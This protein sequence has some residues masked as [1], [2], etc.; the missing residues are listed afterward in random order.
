MQ[1][2]SWGLGTGLRILKRDVG[3]RQE[4]GRDTESRK[5]PQGA[6]SEKERTQGRASKDAPVLLGTD[7]ERDRG[8]GDRAGVAMSSDLP[9]Q[10]SQRK[11]VFNQ[12]LRAAEGA[13]K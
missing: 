10:K 11:P 2:R 3:V 13:V 7:T 6:S 12:L 5:E 1:G 9:L 8:L 4:T